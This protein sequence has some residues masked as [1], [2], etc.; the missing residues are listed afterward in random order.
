LQEW[1]LGR[2][3]VLGRIGRGGMSDVYAAA[4]PEDGQK[5]ALK[6]LR[7]RRPGLAR[8]VSREAEHLRS[9]ESPHVLP[10][11]ELF[12]HDA[13]PVLV[14]P[15]VEGPTLAA[16]LDAHPAPLPPAWFAAIVDGVA[17]IHRAN[18]VHRD[19]KPANVLLDPASGV[20]V[21]KLTDLGLAK[22]LQDDG[23]SLLTRS[24]MMLGTPAYTAP[25]QLASASDAG[26]RADVWS[27]G[28]L[29]VEMWTGQCLRAAPDDLP[30]PW[31][32]L[33]RKLLQPDPEA[34]PADAAAVA[35][36][37]PPVEAAGEEW[38]ERCRALAP[39]IEPAGA[40]RPRG[41]VE[42]PLDPTPVPIERPARGIGTV[43][44]LAGALVAVA[45]GLLVLRGDRADPPPPPPPAEAPA[46]QPPPVAGAATA[47]PPAPHPVPA[48]PVLPQTV[49]KSTPPVAVWV[50]TRPWGHVT[51][52]TQ[53]WSTEDR[54]MR[55][56][57][58]RHVLKLDSHDG[59]YQTEVVL[60]VVAD[61]E[62]RLCWDF[63][64]GAPCS[65]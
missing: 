29:L 28:V 6:V 11:L 4:R 45:L 53:R 43:A 10:L 58:G 5:V 49:R 27:L 47:E 50:K 33:A 30:E 56:P 41:T 24:G 42:T 9:V 55:L 48:A 19:L 14:L 44:V 36:L 59:S 7:D 37:L 39:K 35:A 46:P 1:T 15:F 61:G 21:P 32:N 54:S 23:A 20:V 2:Y 34:R 62:N 38:V 65:R 57:L 25:E 13:G 63:P 12:E 26:P 51:V 64:S 16:M 17:A 3:R 60:E 31:G 52:G 18:R 40:D 22:S 8:R